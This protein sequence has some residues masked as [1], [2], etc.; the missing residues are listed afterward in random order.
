MILWQWLFYEYVLNCGFLVWCVYRASRMLAKASLLLRTIYKI[1]LN[2]LIHVYVRLHIEWISNQFMFY[3]LLLNCSIK[4]R[5]N[6]PNARRTKN[7]V[8]LPLFRFIFLLWLWTWSKILSKK[9]KRFSCLVWE[10]VYFW[11]SELNFDV[12]FWMCSLMHKPSIVY[13]NVVNINIILLAV[14]AFFTLFLVPFT[15]INMTFRI[16]FNQIK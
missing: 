14:I 8:F 4:I 13:C 16:H 1:I 10:N 3:V 12:Y 15:S 11:L 6:Y 2:W 7:T 5:W 9:K